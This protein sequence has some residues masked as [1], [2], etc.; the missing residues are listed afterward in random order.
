MSVD[1][2]GRPRLTRAGYGK[3]RFPK[4]VIGDDGKQFVKGLLN[5]NPQN[6]LGAKRG[7]AEL[8]EHPFFKSIDWELLYKKQITPP[9]KPIVDSDESVANF[10]PEFTNSSLADAGIQPWEDEDYGGSAQQ[11]GRHSYVGPGGSLASPSKGQPGGVAITKAAGARPGLGLPEQNSLLT[12]SVQENFR[13]FTYTG[14]SVMVSSTLGKLFGAD[15]TSRPRCWQIIPWRGS[16]TARTTR[17]RWTTMRTMDPEM[18]RRSLTR[19]WTG[20]GPDGRAMWIWIE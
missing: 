9:F 6:R 13:G 10:D 17:M 8:K 20:C 12:E 4:H 14:E 1:R 3:I 18:R 5:R 19:T 2:E 15:M 7:A 16:T 11:P